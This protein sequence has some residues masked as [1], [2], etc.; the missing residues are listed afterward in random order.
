MPQLG[1]SHK[2]YILDPKHRKTTNIKYE[3]TL[4]NH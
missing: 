4:L 3:V 1:D 2:N